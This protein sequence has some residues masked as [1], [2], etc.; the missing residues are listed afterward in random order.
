MYRLLP[1]ALVALVLHASGV[2]AQACSVNIESSYPAP[3]VHPDFSARLIVGGLTKPRGIIFDKAKNLLVVEAKVGI[4][5]ISFSSDN[6][7]TC[8]AVGDVKTLVQN[9]DLTHGIE[10]SPDGKT[11]YA[12]SASSVFSWTYDAAAG[13]LTDQRTLIVNMNN[14]DHVTR[15]LLLS[16]KEPEMLLI[17]RG[18]G[19]N[20]DRRAA[21]ETSGISQLRAFN[22][23]EI[24]GSPVNFNTAGR[25]VGWGLRN[26]VG[27][28][29]H[30][31]TGAIYTVENSADNIQRL[32]EDIHQDNPAEELNAHPALSSP[33]PPSPLN[34]GYPS[35][36]SLWS[37]VPASPSNATLLPPS[38]PF[39]LDPSDDALCAATVPP[40]L[41]FQAHT[42]PLD[43]KFDA[44]GSAAY[45]S[46]HGSWNRDEP[47]GYD[48]GV[49]RFDA[50]TG[51]PVDGPESREAV[52]Q[53]LGNK[54]VKGC[55]GS[56]FRP[57]GVVVEEEGGRV[58]M[59]SDSTGEVYV[60]KRREAGEAVEEG[61]GGSSAA[62]GGRGVMVM[63]LG[64]P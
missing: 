46:F 52:V 54:D 42:A 34:Y 18:S 39:A 23:S 20:L 6:G 10:I 51:E 61:S 36:L 13:T 64:Y 26:S 59:T 2:T 60:V 32:G 30:P 14:F 48:L 16:R 21:D 11:L 38:T 17:S 19:E 47:V 28:A 50:G 57:V 22:L 4:K 63:V 29:E 58:F 12:S 44:A 37:P 31:V 8:L 53:V 41:V 25:L 35:C 5:R 43:I 33:P 27:V 40:R 55:P 7:L 9:R 15:T 24:T 62:A 1:S 45:V 49:V 3:A 56:C